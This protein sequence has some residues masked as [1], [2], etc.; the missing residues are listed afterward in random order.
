MRRSLSWLLLLGLG[1][2][3]FAGQAATGKVIKVLP[4]YLDLQGRHTLSPSLYERDAYQA[5]LRDN[6]AG[7]MGMRFDVQWKTKG[8]P[9]GPLKLRLELRGLAK[10][11]VPE[12][13]LLEQAVVPGGW[14]SRWTG[15]TLSGDDYKSFGQ[16]TSWRVS[17]WENDQLLGEQ[18]S[19]LW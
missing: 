15:L 4:H 13:F 11:N 2:I 12:E 7:R 6:P 8:Q 17:L 16:V 19:F 18:K 3:P 14:F 9:A 1:W 5:S 10:G